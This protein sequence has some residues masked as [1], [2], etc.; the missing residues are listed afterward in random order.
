MKKLLIILVLGVLIFMI[1]IV[2]YSGK[3]D[4]PVRMQVE[5]QIIFYKNYGNKYLATI[6]KTHTEAH[7]ELQ[8]LLQHQPKIIE[9]RF[10]NFD[11]AVNFIS[12]DDDIKL[13][14]NNIH[15]HTKVAYDMSS[16]GFLYFPMIVRQSAAE[17]LWDTIFNSKE[18]IPH[19]QGY[20]SLSNLT[21][22]RKK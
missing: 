1:F 21:P 4:F 10:D 5:S 8:M 18:E 7:P 13:L 16:D 9:K 6:R 14:N 20:I 17:W 3:K 11:A 12:N 15:K 19:S 2:D 22:V